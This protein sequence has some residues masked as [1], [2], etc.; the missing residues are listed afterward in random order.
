MKL[1]LEIWRQAGP[2]QEGRFETIEVPDAV[3]QMSILELLDHVNSG[4][5]EEGKEPFAF[6]SD[7][8]E[9]IC[10][11]C[12]LTVNGRP[13]GA[14]KN[15][16]ACQ[17]RLVSYHDGDHLRI[18]PLRSN[19]YPVIKDMVVD[20]SALD[21][22]MQKG[23]YV[24]I[25]AGTAPDADT[26]HV[27]HDVA[28]R[29]LDHAACIGCGACVAACPNGAAH[30]FTGAKLVHLKMLP[31]GKEERGKRARQMIDELE[32]NFGPC[33]LYGE[34]A[35]VCPAGIPLTAVAAIN[36]ER[37]RAALRTKDD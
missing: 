5:I 32:T 21:R 16:P 18:E 8:R 6:A 15:K 22:V 10:G 23:G 30:L 11:T 19:A 36:K 7:C 4:L 24:S 26:L 17:Q 13:H 12:G 29:A 35:D 25:N 2:T 31:L 33:S 27:N 3:P 1:T 9:G 14:D 20:R 34:C 37:V 28:E